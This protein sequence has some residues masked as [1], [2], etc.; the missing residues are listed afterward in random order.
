MTSD[1]S[2]FDNSRWLEKDEYNLEAKQ[3]RLSRRQKGSNNRKKTRRRRYCLTDGHKCLNPWLGLSLITLT[4]PQSQNA[5][6][7]VVS[8]LQTWYQLMYQEMCPSLSATADNKIARCRQDF[9]HQ[10]SRRI[11]GQNQVI[12]VENLAVQHMMQNHCLAKGLGQVGW[13]QFCTLLKDKA[14]EE[15]KVYV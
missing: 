8:G 2:R 3:R 14:K 4:S 13:G 6:T 11:V 12:V 15:G 9:Q 7:P 1:G 5:K 10:L